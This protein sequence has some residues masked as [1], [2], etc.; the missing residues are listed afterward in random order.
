WTTFLN[1]ATPV[2]WGTEKIAQKLDRPIIYLGI[3]RPQRGYYIM[4]FEVLETEPKNT[5][6]GYISE[7]HTR[8]LEQDIRK[9]PA[10]WLWTHRRWKH[11]PPEGSTPDPG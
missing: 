10:I 2:F 5:P 4:R 6:E 11:R 3:D 1:Q 9:R 8:R 7:L